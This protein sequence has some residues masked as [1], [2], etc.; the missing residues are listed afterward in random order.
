MG[1]DHFYNGGEKSEEII[2]KRGMFFT[3]ISR[4]KLSKKKH[5]SKDKYISKKPDKIIFKTDLSINDIRKSFSKDISSFLSSKK[6]NYSEETKND[7]LKDK[8]YST[9]LNSTTED[10]RKTNISIK[11]Q[12][13]NSILDTN[14][15]SRKSFYQKLISKNILNINKEKIKNN[16]LFIFDWDDTLFFTTHLNP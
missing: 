9:S 10:F 12:N 1:F 4:E 5:V 6:Y 8:Q 13:I 16:T 3:Q 14:E 2:E 11:N 15:T 7:D